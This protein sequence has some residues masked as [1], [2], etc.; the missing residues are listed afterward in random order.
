MGVAGIEGNAHIVEVA[1]LQN[2]EKVFWRGD[3]VMQVFE[4]AFDAER[5]GEGLEVF[6]WR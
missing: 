4:Q 1:D 5:M 3:F 6:L 2:F